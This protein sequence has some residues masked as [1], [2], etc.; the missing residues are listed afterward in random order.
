MKIHEYQAKALLSDYGVPIPSGAVAETALQARQIAADFGSGVVIK[1]Q[2]HAG[3]RGKAGGVKVA[4][5]ADEA[6]RLASELI[7][8]TLVTHQT[9]PK[10]S[11]VRKVLVE[12]AAV[13]ARELY[14]S[15]VIDRVS[16]M[17]VMTGS[18]AGGM[19]I[20]A[21]AQSSP[22]RLHKIHVDPAVGFRQFQGRKLAYGMGLGSDQTNL[23]VKLM[24]NL[25]ELF[26]AKDCSLVEINPLVVTDQGDLV[27]LDAKMDFDD[28]ALFRHEDIRQLHDPEQD[29]PLEVMA[30]DLGMKNY[31]KLTGNIGCMVNGPAWPWQCWI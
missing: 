22:E 14:L 24:E 25:Y 17:P 29:D 26:I 11:P 2:I 8:K 6:E 23:A 20:E 4:A 16:R 19:D 13:A 7:G 1:A 28:S 9:S 15:I 18:E 30:V 12:R 31:L 10:G 5:N 21:V 3:G 27:A